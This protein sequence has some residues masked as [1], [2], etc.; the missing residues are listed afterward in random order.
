MTEQETP[1]G[2]PKEAFI[3]GDTAA[4][5]IEETMRLTS[6]KGLRDLAVKVWNQSDVD[7][8]IGVTFRCPK[9]RF[10]WWAYGPLVELGFQVTGNANHSGGNGVIVTGND[11]AGEQSPA[12]AVWAVLHCHYLWVGES[13]AQCVAHIKGLS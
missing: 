12:Y 1:T 6:I 9:Y 10:L 7:W 8:T 13:F 5:L 4:T 3:P 2:L 11:G